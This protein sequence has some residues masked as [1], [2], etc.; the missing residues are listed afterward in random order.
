[1]GDVDAIIYPSLGESFGLP[2]LEARL[3]NKPV[4]AADLSYVY[5]VIPPM[6]VFNPHSARSIAES[7]IR[8]LGL[9]SDIS[10]VYSSAEFNKIWH[11]GV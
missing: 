9:S 2:L 7:V 11:G 6:E 4:I 3:L 5:D 10:K 8:F 1:M